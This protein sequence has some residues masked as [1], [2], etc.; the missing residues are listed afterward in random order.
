MTSERQIVTNQQNALKSTGPQT[1]EGKA[2][3]AK[4]AIKHGLF[5]KVV[6]VCEDEREL[7]M[8]FLNSV[9]E[10]FA[11][12]NPLESALVERVIANTWRL[13]R[14]AEIET[15]I[16]TR[17]SMKSI[18]RQSLMVQAQSNQN[19]ATLSRYEQNLE[20]SLFRSLQAL[21]KLKNVLRSLLIP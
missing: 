17:E 9:F 14:V 10:Y 19:M 2:I 20:K 7:F 5:S 15:L 12:S 18:F 16:L 21:E 11:P 6:V 1:I 4:N 13:R 3:V 8:E